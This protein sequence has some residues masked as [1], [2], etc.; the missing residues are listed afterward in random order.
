MNINLDDLETKQTEKTEPDLL[1]SDDNIIKLINPYN[2]DN[3]S[4]KEI[5]NDDD[6]K[7]S[8]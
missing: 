7:H 4:D 5:N 8:I 6:A 3:P 2:Q 1:D